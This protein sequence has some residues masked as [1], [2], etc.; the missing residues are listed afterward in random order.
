MQDLKAFSGD[1]FDARDWINQTFRA[2]TE[3]QRQG[4]E[5]HASSLVTKLQLLIAKLNSS[6]EEQ[7]EQV[8]QGVPRVV[9]E[10]ESLQQEAQLLMAK[11]SA[12]QEE[13]DRVNDETG[14]SMEALVQM[15]L[16]KQRI[17]VKKEAATLTLTLIQCLF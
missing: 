17:Q 11:M 15:D 6:V 13:I 14:T 4:K 8:S 16:F 10:T 2:S 3:A 12:V 9:R 5:Q 7:S 1:S